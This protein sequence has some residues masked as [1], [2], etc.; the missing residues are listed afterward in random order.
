MQT[1]RE[2]IL[3][4]S[5]YGPVNSGAWE[6]GFYSTNSDGLVG[7]T[8]APSADAVRDILDI[9]YTYHIPLLEWDVLVWNNLYYITEICD[10]VISVINEIA[11]TFSD[12][13]SNSLI[14]EMKKIQA[15][16]SLGDQLFDMI[17]P[18][19][20]R[21][22]RYIYDSLSTENRKYPYLPA[23]SGIVPYAA[24]NLGTISRLPIFLDTDGIQDKRIF[25]I[26][27]PAGLVEFLR[28][29]ASRS[30]VSSDFNT[31][32]IVKL[33]VWR[34]NLLTE[35]TAQLPVEYLFDVKRFMLDGRRSAPKASK[36]TKGIGGRHDSAR[37]YFPGQT[38]D[39]LFKNARICRYTDSGLAAIYAGTAYSDKALSAARDNGSLSA[40]SDKILPTCINYAGKSK[41]ILDEIF[42][43]HVVDH[44]LKL[45][46][47]LTSGIDVREEVFCF[48][49]DKTQIT[50]PDKDKEVLRKEWEEKLRS[51]FETRD[52]A[53]RLTYQRMLGELDRSIF[54][55][56][57]KYKNRII[58]PKIFDRVF[59]IYIDESMWKDDVPE[60]NES[61]NIESGQNAYEN[62]S[63]ESEATI[64]SLGS[65]DSPTY[66]QY[67]VTVSI[68]SELANKS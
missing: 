64:L 28:R 51:L 47:K 40:L 56:S 53:S 37:K 26:G 5:R 9:F 30:L 66:Y 17:T 39:D 27:L 24:K 22:S 10:S 20:V 19:Q 55:S 16:P 36:G 33:S 6:P 43:N 23:S 68:I 44:Y 50:G 62:V 59:C 60:S 67:Y 38:L 15:D 11:S 41:T 14:T 57:E 65:S 1:S 63:A 58:Y 48:Q 21:L 31:S 13:G 32:S 45:Y 46:L 12:A 35:T 3:A 29:S 61:T 49:N 8:G 2:E 25:A 54:L 52:M 7:T 42:Y 18:E 4:D 34:R